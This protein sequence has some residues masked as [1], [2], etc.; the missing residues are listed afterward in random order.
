M[1]PTETTASNNQ[2]YLFPDIDDLFEQELFI[3]IAGQLTQKWPARDDNDHKFIAEKASK[4]T[5]VLAD[6]YQ[7]DFVK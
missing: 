1:Q 2:T 6:T 5:R 4:L 3:E 7:R